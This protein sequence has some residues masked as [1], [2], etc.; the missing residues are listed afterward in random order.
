MDVEPKFAKFGDYWDDST[1]DKVIELLRKYYDI[2]PTKFL[3]LKG[4]IYNLE[5]MKI[6]LKSDAKPVKQRPITL[7]PN[8]REGLL[9]VG[10]NAYSRYY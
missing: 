1:V 7:I 6:T 10:K 9:G 3:N 2:F 5:V 4:I 8:T